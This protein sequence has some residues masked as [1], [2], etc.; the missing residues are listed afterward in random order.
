MAGRNSSP[1]QVA[2]QYAPANP[3]KSAG[4][5]F[6]NRYKG[7]STLT[8]S[9]TQRITI[10]P[11]QGTTPSPFS[12][13][14][15][16][17]AGDEYTLLPADN[18]LDLEVPE[19]AYLNM[20][21]SEQVKA[22]LTSR[23][24][25]LE[26]LIKPVF[27]QDN[28]HTFYIEPEVAERTVEQ[29]ETWVPPTP[30]PVAF[31]PI[32]LRAWQEQHVEPQ[33]PDGEQALP[34]RS[35]TRDWLVNPGTLVRIDGQII[36]G[37]RGQVPLSIQPAAQAGARPGVPVLVNGAG[38]IDAAEVAVLGEGLTLEQVGL[39][40]AAGGLHLVGAAGVNTALMINLDRPGKNGF[41]AGTLD[42]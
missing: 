37:P 30:P 4:T 2:G 17:D 35:P 9:F 10:D 28:E 24:A 20:T 11:E 27:Y 5:F 26:S 32:K 42:R 6:A 34:G 1:K 40:P 16:G 21:N 18:R 19:A 23:L 38:A 36:M 15:L 12:A 3:Y 39:T 13:P 8:V 14:V 33:F 22:A 7:A 25:E 29:W 41:S 31:D